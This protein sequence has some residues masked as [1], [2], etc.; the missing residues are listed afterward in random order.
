MN[1]SS[2]PPSSLGAQVQT[3]WAFARRHTVRETYAFLI[4]KEAPFIVQVA[5]Y[6]FC[7]VIATIVHN[8]V[9]WWLSLS[10]FPAFE[11]L[12]PAELQR[13][14]INANLVALAVSN[15][16]AYVSNALWVFTGGRHG[17]GVEF[18]LFSTVTLISGLAG[19][20]AGPF[21]RASL[22]TNWWIAQLTMIITAALVNFVC[23]K[24]FVFQK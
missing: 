16:V 23:R 21:L 9:A 1:P 3:V 24:F 11:G 5:K 15:V 18:L 14:Q 8:G 2:A 17:R 22:G 10:V 19:I 13:N 7:G 20:L 12:E 6:G 4:S